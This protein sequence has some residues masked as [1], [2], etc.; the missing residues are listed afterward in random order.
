MIGRSTEV[1]FKGL[2]D[3]VGV[4]TCGAGEFVSEGRRA[5]EGGVLQLGMVILC[6]LDTLN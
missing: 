6:V 2:Q 1:N 4:I 3:G 5:I